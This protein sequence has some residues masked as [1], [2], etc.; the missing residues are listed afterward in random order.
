MIPL[1]L[2]VIALLGAG[3][4]SPPDSLVVPMWADTSVEIEANV[5]PPADAVLPLFYQISW[6]DGDTLNWRSTAMTFG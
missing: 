2:S 5:F 4:L 1:T 3:P 6:G